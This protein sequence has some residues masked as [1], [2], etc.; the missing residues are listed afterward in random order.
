MTTLA[1]AD[2]SPQLRAAIERARVI[3]PVVIAYAR[4][5]GCDDHTASQAADEALRFQGSVLDAIRAGRR[6]ANYLRARQWDCAIARKEP[7]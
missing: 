7:A 6:R 3:S 5:I 2:A 4:R 1:L